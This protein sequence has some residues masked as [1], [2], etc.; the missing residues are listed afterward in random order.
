MKKENMLVIEDEDIMR[1]ALVDYFSEGGHTV[2]TAND[3]EKALS[4]CLVD[5]IVG[6]REDVGGAR[7]PVGD[8]PVHATSANAIETTAAIPQESDTSLRL[9]CRVKSLIRMQVKLV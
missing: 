6:V 4:N 1:E 8:R 7:V 3:G 2:D 5:E 9:C